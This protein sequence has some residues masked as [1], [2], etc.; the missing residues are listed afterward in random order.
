MNQAFSIRNMG[1]LKK[2]PFQVMMKSSGYNAQLDVIIPL[3]AN[4]EP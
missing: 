4:M 3:K 1:A 2:N